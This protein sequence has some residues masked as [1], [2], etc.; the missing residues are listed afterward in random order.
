M[1][2]DKNRNFLWEKL[3]GDEKDNISIL[4]KNKY[5]QFCTEKP[6]EH[7]GGGTIADYYK[8]QIEDFVLDVLDVLNK[9]PE[10]PNNTLNK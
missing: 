2:C 3:T 1:M 6:L 4:I 9:K 10:L 5:C 8:Y 7:C